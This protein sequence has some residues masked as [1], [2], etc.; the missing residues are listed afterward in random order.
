MQRHN[1]V[2]SRIAV[3]LLFFFCGLVFASWASRIPIF[4]DQ[5]HLNEAQ[6]GGILFMLPLGSFIALPF[7]GWAVDHFGS[8]IMATVAAVLYVVALYS[9]AWCNTIILLSA[10]LFIFGFIGDTLNIAMNTQGLD[11]QQ[12]YNQPILSSFHGLWSLGALTGALIGG[13]TLKQQFSTQ[14]HFLLVLVPVVMTAIAMFFFLLPDHA[15]K[16]DGKKLLAMPDRSLWIIGVICFCCTIC[17]GGMADWS[18]LYYQEV[19][20]DPSKVSTHAFT[21]YVFTMAIGRFSGDRLIRIFRYKRMLILDGILIAT[22]M[23]LA[24]VSTI[25]FMVIIGFSLVGFGVSTVIP[26]SYTMAGKSSSMKASAA[27]AAVSTI[28]FTGFMIGPPIIGFIAH[29]TSLRVALC[30]VILLGLCVLMLA[31][32]AIRPNV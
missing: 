15:R 20:D 19:L 21:A 13:W 27:L 25:P 14:G 3:A 2:Y 24:L 29:E 9:L 30:L 18:A 26:I 16:E 8:R 1:I 32:K 4:K 28:G 22:G 23:M 17:E 12:A 11:V 7:A 5:F 6:L 31:K 10:G